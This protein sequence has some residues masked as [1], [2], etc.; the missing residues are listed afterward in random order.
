MLLI[1]LTHP[2]LTLSTSAPL[3]VY[4]LLLLLPF[5]LLLL[6][7]FFLPFL[8][9]TSLI[10]STF[11]LTP[12]CCHYSALVIPKLL[13][14]PKLLIFFYCFPLALLIGPNLSPHHL[15]SPMPYTTLSCSIFLRFSS[16][17]FTL[18][19]SYTTRITREIS[20]LNGE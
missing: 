9:C 14:H 19:L 20:N 10:S 7:P 18:S 4:N 15:T 1:N 2:P 13:L 5:I 6:F 3:T 17:P 12:S 8:Y 16:V 11:S